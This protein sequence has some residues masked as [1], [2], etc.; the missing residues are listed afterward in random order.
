MWLIK[1]IDIDWLIQAPRCAWREDATH[2]GPRQVDFLF[3][4][5][6]EE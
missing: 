2:I 5:D 1:M 6:K 3:I 4:W